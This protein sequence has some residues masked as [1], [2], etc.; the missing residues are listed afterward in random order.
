VNDPLLEDDDK[1]DLIFGK[2]SRPDFFIDAVA[3][4]YLQNNGNTSPNQAYFW[5]FKDGYL[6]LH[7]HC[8]F[9][10][11]A[12]RY[13]IDRTFQ[14][15]IAMLSN[16]SETSFINTLKPEHSGGVQSL[17]SGTLQTAPFSSYHS[18]LS[19]IFQPAL[20]DI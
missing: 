13:F 1:N 11:H 4:Q 12:K 16:I 2:N 9:I 18:V 19:G 17:L 8:H 5:K 10:N 20:S 6:S 7:A 3:D 15:F 14:C